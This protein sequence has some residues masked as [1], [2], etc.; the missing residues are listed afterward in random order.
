MAHLE[1]VDAQTLGQSL[2]LVLQENASVLVECGD[3]AVDAERDGYQ[4]VTEQPALNT[5]ERQN[6]L[7]PGGRFREKVIGLVSENI[8]DDVLP[9][10][11]VEKRRFG[12]AHDEGVPPRRIGRA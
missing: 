3:A 11:S 8:L 6:T 9:A 4:R 2:R 12:T 5:S 7:N 1:I 10:G